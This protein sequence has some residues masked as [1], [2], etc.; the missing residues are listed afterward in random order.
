M[1]RGAPALFRR[2][3]YPPHHRGP[4]A[5]HPPI[6]AAART[7]R[8]D[9]GG[10]DD[11]PHPQALRH[12]R[13]APGLLLSGRVAGGAPVR[14]DLRVPESGL[15]ELRGGAGPRLP[16]DQYPPRSPRRRGGRADLSAPRGPGPLPRFGGRPSRGEADARFSRPDAFRDGAGAGALRER[17]PAAAAGRSPTPFRGADHGGN[18]LRRADGDRANRIR[19]LPTPSQPFRGP[20]DRHRAADLSCRSGLRGVALTDERQGARV[21]PEPGIVV[22]G[23][24]WAGLSCAAALAERGLPITLLE[25]RPRLGGRACSFADAVTGDEIDNGQHLFMAC[26]KESLRFLGRIGTAD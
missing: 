1:G 18:L 3:P 26:F 4:P 22:V 8:R 13:G 25:E 15:A 16:D 23:G 10:G 2:A 19:C 14:R 21:E 7:L 6:L 20:Q 11:R 24:G 5:G 12:L 9:P 17:E